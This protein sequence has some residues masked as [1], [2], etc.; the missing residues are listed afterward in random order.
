[1]QQLF[2]TNAQADLIQQE[3]VVAQQINIVHNLQEAQSQ[4]TAA[5]EAQANNYLDFGLLSP[6]TPIEI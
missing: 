5:A 4:S 6:N 1:M 3:V 2:L